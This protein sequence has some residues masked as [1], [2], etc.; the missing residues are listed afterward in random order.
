MLDKKIIKEIKEGLI[1][2]EKELIEVL[3]DLSKIDSHEADSLSA[4][5]PEYGDKA[6]ENAQE[7]GD[8]E[9]IKGK[10]RILEKSLE[11]VRGALKRIDNNTYG[12]CK[13]CSGEIGEKRL[14]ARPVA[15]SCISCK[16][17]L[18]GND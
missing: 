11:D 7:V 8:W 12:I 3:K 13:Y 9:A 16:K 4:K 17:E 18:Q 2:R 14:K 1:K 15:S 5:F 6:D 10:E